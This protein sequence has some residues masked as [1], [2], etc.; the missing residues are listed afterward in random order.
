VLHVRYEVFIHKPTLEDFTEVKH[1]LQ[2][3]IDNP[4][5]MEPVRHRYDWRYGLVN[6][7]PSS[8]RSPYPARLPQPP[9]G[10]PIAVSLLTA[11]RSWP[12]SVGAMRR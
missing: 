5:G 6:R 7:M 10:W 2:E 12:G 11:R 3:A 8:T 4:T 1:D 9:Q